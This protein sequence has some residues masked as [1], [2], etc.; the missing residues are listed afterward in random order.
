MGETIHKRNKLSRREN[1]IFKLIIGGKT[2]RE[3]REIL[4][5]CKGTLERHITNIYQKKNVRNRI[6]LLNKHFGKEPYV[7]CTT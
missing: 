6:E 4:C 5:I 3:I 1:E 2:N 7:N